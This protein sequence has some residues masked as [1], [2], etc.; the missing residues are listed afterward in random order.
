[1]TVDENSCHVTTVVCLDKWPGAR[2]W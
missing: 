2:T 1:M